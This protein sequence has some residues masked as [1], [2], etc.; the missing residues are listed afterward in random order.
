MNDLGPVSTDTGDHW[1][2]III[3]DDEVEIKRF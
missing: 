3:L 1:R 2:L